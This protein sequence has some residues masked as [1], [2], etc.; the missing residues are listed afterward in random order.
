MSKEF[1]WDVQLIGRFLEDQF[2]HIAKVFIARHQPKED[3]PDRDYSKYDFTGMQKPI[4]QFKLD[5]EI[6]AFKNDV[7]GIWVLDESP[8]DK[9]MKKRFMGGVKMNWQIHSVK[10]LSDNEVF[11]VGEITDGGNKIQ[12]FEVTENHLRVRMGTVATIKEGWL[13]NIQSLV[14]K[15]PQKEEQ[16][17]YVKI[18][19]DKPLNISMREIASCITMF[20][21]QG[22]DVSLSNETSVIDWRKLDDI[23]KSKQ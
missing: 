17:R 13:T 1:K 7:E 21:Y 11:T 18:D 5:W 20:V 6:V 15:Q 19:V 23:L 2:P 12:A 9:E 22:R 14:K 3:K 16:A 8:F 4:P 10:R